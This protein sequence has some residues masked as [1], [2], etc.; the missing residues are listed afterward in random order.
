MLLSLAEFQRQHRAEADARCRALFG[1]FNIGHADIAAF[2]PFDKPVEHIGRIKFNVDIHSLCGCNYKKL[3]LR[4]NDCGKKHD[5]NSD[6]RRLVVSRTDGKTD[7]GGDDEC[8]NDADGFYPNVSPGASSQKKDTEK[9][10]NGD[11]DTDVDDTGIV[12]VDDDNGWYVYQKNLKIFSNAAFEYTN[13][14]KSI[15]LPI[16]ITTLGSY[17]FKD[18]T[19]LLNIF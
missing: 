19:Q 7:D 12:Y 6:Q 1:K 17:V 3:K 9:K 18:N 13:N 10:I 8:S 11:T 5:H 14:L 2:K 16:T 4:E 15:Y